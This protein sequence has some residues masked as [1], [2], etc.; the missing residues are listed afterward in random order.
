MPYEAPASLQEGLKKPENSAD[1]IY[2]WPI[3]TD[4][5]II[6]SSSLQS[7][8]STVLF[9]DPECEHCDEVFQPLP[10]KIRMSNKCVIVQCDAI[11]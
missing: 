7:V 5:L 4:G 2:G 8:K 10:Q 1:V 11:D 3:N 9:T 6:I